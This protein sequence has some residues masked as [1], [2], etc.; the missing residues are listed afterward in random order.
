M[1]FLEAVSRVFPEGAKVT[2]CA[3][4][5]PTIGVEVHNLQRDFVPTNCEIIA[6]GQFQYFADQEC[7]HSYL[8]K[9]RN[10]CCW[11]AYCPAAERPAT[12]MPKCA[13]ASLHGVRRPLGATL[14][15]PVLRKEP[16]TNSAYAIWRWL[17]IEAF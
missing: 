3:S 2:D 8:I 7:R 16:H 9:S 4:A 15:C 1:N 13:C 10:T 5:H 12:S 11:C 6:S 17:W 14:L